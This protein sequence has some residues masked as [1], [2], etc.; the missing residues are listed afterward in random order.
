MCFISRNTTAAQSHPIEV[1]KIKLKQG[2]IN[3]REQLRPTRVLTM[4]IKQ[5]SPIPRNMLSPRSFHMHS[6]RGINVLLYW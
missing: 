5:T 1:R 4:I 2:K 6:V 3:D